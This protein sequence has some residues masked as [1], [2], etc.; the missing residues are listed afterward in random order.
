IGVW[1]YRFLAA[2]GIAV[3]QN[4]SSNDTYTFTPTSDSVYKVFYQARNTG[5]SESIDSVETSVT[6]GFGADVSII[7]YDCVNLGGTI[8]LDNIFGQSTGTVLYNNPMSA[9]SP[10][11]TF[12]GN[13]SINGGRAVMT[14][15]QTSASGTMDINIPGFAAGIN[16]S[17]NV[18]FLLTADMP[19]NVFGTGGGDGLAYSFGNDAVSGGAGPNANGKG[20]KLRLSFDAAN[21]GSN[22]AGIYLIYGYTG[23]AAIPVADPATLAFSPNLASWKLLTDVPVVM[24]INTQGKVTVT[25]GSTVIFS[26]VQ[27]PASYMTEDVSSWKH[28]FSANTGGDALR[29]AVSNVEISTSSL[30]FAFVPA[31]ATPTFADFDYTNSVTNVQPGMYDIWLAQDSSNVCSRMIGTYEVM[32]ANPSVDLGNDTTICE[33]QTLTLDA[34]NPGS[35]YIWSNSNNTNQTYTIS[36]SGSYVAYVTGA[37]SCV[38]VSTIN[39]SVIDAPTVSG[40]YSQGNFPSVFLSATNPQNVTNYSWDFGDNTTAPNGPSSISHSY[41]W[42]GTYTVT[43]TVTN[44]CGTETITQVVNVNDVTGIDE[45]TIAGLNIYPNPSN[46]LVT[47]SLANNISA[48]AKVVS[49]TGSIVANFE[50]ANGQSIMD[51]TEW[52]KGIY[53]IQIQSEEKVAIT[54]LVVQ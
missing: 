48:S 34:G 4:W 45:N 37:N 1:E 40:I 42:P 5:C 30:E 43:L 24:S 7:D 49:T 21:N 26:D 28:L 22:T 36:N 9:V 17:L 44:D 10:E 23:S 32:N 51:V 41:G 39:V 13:A 27:L 3:L 29:H 20:S 12:T 15:S 8:S 38:G 52:E 35:S 46:S 50:I 19:I 54:K 31:G 16:N 47:I 53:F 18:S 6:V 33:G 11:L 14:P 2:D 25:V